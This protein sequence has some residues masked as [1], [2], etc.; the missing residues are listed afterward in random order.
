MSG[1]RL[2]WRSGGYFFD[3]GLL[4]TTPGEWK[5]WA[6]T[7]D[8]A[9]QGDFTGTPSLV[10]TFF[11]TENRLLQDACCRLLGDAGST[12]AIHK[13]AALLRSRFANLD[14][15]GG[16]DALD[17]SNALGVHGQLL[18]VPEILRIFEWNLGIPDSKIFAHHLSR[19]LEP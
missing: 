9:K 2:D 3:A 7:F 14:P 6:H 12:E 18:C 17:L 8:R 15:I 1:I 5:H 4:K 19:M 16:D 10:D 13:A 11:S